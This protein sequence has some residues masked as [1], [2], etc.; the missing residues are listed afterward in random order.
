MIFDSDDHFQFSAFR[1]P[2]PLAPRFQ[3]LN[4]QQ[5]FSAAKEKRKGSPRGNTTYESCKIFRYFSR[6]FES[7]AFNMT[8]KHDLYTLSMEQ[9]AGRGQS[10]SCRVWH[11]NQTPIPQ[12]RWLY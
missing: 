2:F 5:P 4:F 9:I 11:L 12:Q 1:I 6:E 10:C 7:Q 8:L 3:S